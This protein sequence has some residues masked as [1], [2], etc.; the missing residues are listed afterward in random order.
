[1]FDLL[2]HVRRQRAF[3]EKTFGPG[4]RTGALTE[5]IRKELI[6]IENDPHDLREWIDV[7]CLALDGAWRAGYTPEEIVNELD[8]TLTRNETR[9]WPDWRSVPADQPI[10]HLHDPLDE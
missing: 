2:Q 7:I 5:H 3:S 10:E 6:E 1:M 8:A 9:R 4:P